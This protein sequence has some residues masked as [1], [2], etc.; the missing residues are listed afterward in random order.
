MNCIKLLGQSLM[1][2][3]FDSQVAEFQVRISVLNRYTV[4]GTHITEAVGQIRSGKG[5]VC[6][7]TDLCNTA[8]ER[9][10]I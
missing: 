9:R 6:P 1:A 7:S 8:D 4:V 5:A 3:D 10:Y 2:R